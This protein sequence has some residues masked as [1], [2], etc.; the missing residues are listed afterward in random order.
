MGK[1]IL[2]KWRNVI[3]TAVC[4]GEPTEKALVS[5]NRPPRQ[6]LRR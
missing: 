4:E 3:K 2:S 1:R 5:S 6:I